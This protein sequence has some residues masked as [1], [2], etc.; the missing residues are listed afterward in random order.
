MSHHIMRKSFTSNTLQTHKGIMIMFFIKVIVNTLINIFSYIIRVMSH[1][2]MRKSFTSNT[3]QTHK[4]T[5]MAL[6]GI[7]VENFHNLI[8]SIRAMSHQSTGYESPYFVL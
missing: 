6:L 8:S 1:P 3:L 5:V 2:I 4:Q 7:N